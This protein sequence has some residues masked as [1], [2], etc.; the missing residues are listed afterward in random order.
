MSDPGCPSGRIWLQLCGQ[1]CMS[2][3][4]NPRSHPTSK[5]S[6]PGRPTGGWPLG[7]SLDVDKVRTCRGRAGERDSE[8]CRVGVAP[9]LKTRSGPGRSP[10]PGTC[11]QLRGRSGCPCRW[12]GWPTPQRE[13]LSL[14]ASP[15]G[16]IST[17]C[18]RHTEAK[19][20]AGSPSPGG[21]DPGTPQAM[22]GAVPPPGPQR[23]G[24]APIQGPARLAQ[25]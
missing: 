13:G 11:T 25:G 12:V 19:H 10:P 1:F 7:Q 9:G 14:E 22:P 5:A 21:R 3:S 2:W 18:L 16:W 4:T 8:L 6:L 24:T 20:L 17:W 15:R 23:L